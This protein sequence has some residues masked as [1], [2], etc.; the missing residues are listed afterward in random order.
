MAKA[1]LILGSASPFRKKLLEDAGF[2]FEV[3]T[4]DI[5]EKQIRHD[6]FK[7]LVLDLAGKKLEA[8]LANNIFDP[9][10]IIVTFDCV[11][12]H[13]G[14]LREKPISREE[15]LAWHAEYKNS[16]TWLHGGIA[17][18]HVGKNKTLQAVDSSLITW[19][20]IP[21]RVIR[22]IAEDPM[23]YRA[24]GFTDRSFLH[25]TKKVEGS[26]DTIVGVPLRI[27][28]QFLEELGYYE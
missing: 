27:L 12:E 23:T 22:E 26:I 1:K 15:V 8:I 21:D 10:T 4:A 3:R 7:K 16:E 28:E 11:A 19:G 17:V 20:D 18:H 6:D 24:A 13:N 5:D 2:T 14:K 9:D 25:Y